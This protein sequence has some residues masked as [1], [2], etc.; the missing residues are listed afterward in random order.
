MKKKANC[1]AKTKIDEATHRTITEKLWA[2]WSPEQI[3]GRLFDGEIA[4][5]T[6]HRWIYSER[7]DVPTSVLRQRSGGAGHSGIGSSTPS[8]SD[9]GNRR[10][11]VHGA[12]PEG[13][14]E[15]ATTDRGKAISGHERI[16]ATLGVPMYFADPYSSWQRGS[17]ENA[18]GILREFFPNGTDFARVTHDELADALAKFNGR[19]RKCLNWKTAHEVFTEEVLRL[20]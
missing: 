14:F 19:L 3:V 20:I 1:D 11:A 15:T 9:V 5:S 16:R 2:T 6:I 4:F 7:I 8:S 13:T 17:N 12:F 10:R 18:N